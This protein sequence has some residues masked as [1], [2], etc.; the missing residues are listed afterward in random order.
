MN[1][2]ATLSGIP[3]KLGFDGSR[4]ADAWLQGDVTRIVKYNE[5]DALT[6]YLL[7]LRMANVAG[8]IPS[9]T[10]REEQDQLR[11]LL[12]ERSS[13]PDHEHLGEYLTEW[14]RLRSR[15]ASS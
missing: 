15:V 10:Y 2:I 7:W 14:D 6:T 4:T 12:V 8:L 5:H 9:N 1:Q 3:G 13:E 11:S